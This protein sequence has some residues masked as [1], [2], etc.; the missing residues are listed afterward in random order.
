M[1]LQKFDYLEVVE[2]AMELFWRKGYKAASIKEVFD[3]AN[4]NPGSLYNTFQSKSGIFKIAL[5]HY[6][7]K[8]FDRLNDDLMHNASVEIGICNFLLRDIRNTQEAGFCG[9]FLLKSQLELQ[10]NGDRELKTIAS[11]N[12]KRLESLFFEA[13]TTCCLYESEAHMKASN[14]MFA[15]YGVH[16]YVY[17]NSDYQSI[18][19]CV[20]EFLPWLPWAEA[21]EMS[22]NDY[23]PF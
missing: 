17:I 15:W 13:L 4:I 8:V 18:L 12:L 22:V 3:V 2:S 20:L 11:K 1:T 16:T 14:I 10:F 19:T 5:D 9:C 21:L 23:R 6:A 7:N